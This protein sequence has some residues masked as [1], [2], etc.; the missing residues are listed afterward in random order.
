MAKPLLALRGVKTNIGRYHILHGVEFEVAEGGLTMLLGRNGAGKTTTLRT[1]MGLWRAAEG[2]IRFA[3][4][5]IAK[6]STPDIARLGIAYVPESMAI[7]A[8]LTVQENLIL[9]ARAGPPDPKRLDWIFARFEA[10]KRFWHLPA[11][12]LSGGQKQMLAVARAIVEP[13]R[14]LLIDEPTKG[15]A[16]AIIANMIAAFRELKDGESTL[17]VVEQN[18]AFA[19]QLGDTVAVMDDGKVAHTGTMAAFA[20]DSALQQHL[21]GLGMDTHQ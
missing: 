7:F 21:L 19:R 15:L 11:G 17:L 2:E 6:L 10:L 14:L 4:R 5:D 1:I 16:P 8:D 13:R 20:A 12:H 9:A 18:F 3:G